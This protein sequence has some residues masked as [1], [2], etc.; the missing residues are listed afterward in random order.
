MTGPPLAYQAF[1]EAAKASGRPPTEFLRET[2]PVVFLE[3]YV[4]MVP[5][6]ANVV[7]VTG[8]T[9]EYVYDNYAE[10][11]ATGVVEPDPVTE[12]RLVCAVG[13]SR[14][15]ESRRDDAR[16]RG[17]VG[18]TGATFGEGWDK[19]HF[20][21]HT[22]GGAIDGLEMNVFLQ[23]RSVNRGGYRRLERYCAANPGVLCF[24][25]PIYSGPSAT[26][27]AVEFGVLTLDGV[28]DIETFSNQ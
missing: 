21:A 23:R 27:S 9:F 7:S 15:N 5:R 19:G 16:L 26:P 2:L 18:P 13:I 25:R 28:F 11:E 20:I 17:W 3:A 6:R 1:L 4:E 8:G 22:M 24:S 10:L 14:M 12:S